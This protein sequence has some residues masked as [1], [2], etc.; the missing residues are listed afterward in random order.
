MRSQVEMKNIGNWRKGES[1][2]KVT[3]ENKN[4]TNLAELY[5]YP[6][7]LWKVELSSNDIEYLAEPISKHSVEGA[8]SF[9]LVAYCDI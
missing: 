8:A 9:L 1:C 4:K 5:L 2:Y 6:R 3:K 7:V